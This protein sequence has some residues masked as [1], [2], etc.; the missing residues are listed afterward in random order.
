MVSETTATIGAPAELLLICVLDSA[1]LGGT[2][3]RMP[4]SRGVITVLRMPTNGREMILIGTSRN[5][6]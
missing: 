3:G 2:G 4:I 5:E 1:K 6:M